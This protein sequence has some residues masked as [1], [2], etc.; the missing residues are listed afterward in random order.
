MDRR[1]APV[2]RGFPGDLASGV[3]AVRCPR[4]FISRV[5]ISRAFGPGVWVP[6]YWTQGI[7]PRILDSVKRRCCGGPGVSG[8][9]ADP[10]AAFVSDRPCVGSAGCRG[11]WIGSDQG[12]SQVKCV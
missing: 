6:R 3:W 11:V 9:V 2:L 8:P 4:V 12:A 7:G 1:L 5:F 10:V